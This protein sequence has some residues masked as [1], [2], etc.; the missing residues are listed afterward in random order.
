MKHLLLVVL[1]GCI[2]ANNIL[3]YDECE[4]SDLGNIETTN[5]NNQ[6]NIYYGVW[7]CISSTEIY[8]GKTYTGLQVGETLTI[9][10][11]GTYKSTSSDMGKSGIF[12]VEGNSFIATTNDGRGISATISLPDGLLTMEGLSDE[13]V[14][15]TYVFKKI[16][17]SIPIEYCGVWDCISSTETYK[18][19]TYTGLQ[20]GEAI[21]IDAD[22]TYESTSSDIGKAGTFVLE[23]NIFKATTNDGRGISATISLSDDLLTMEGF[24]EEGVQFSYVFKVT[25]D[26]V[27]FKK[28]SPMKITNY[29]GILVIEGVKNGK[30]VTIYSLSGVKIGAAI[31]T[32]H[33]AVINTALQSGNIVLIKADGK[34]LKYKCR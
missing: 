30:L 7:E 26:K 11:N 25:I 31:A 18:G 13:G 16:G 28:T 19:K 5:F 1:L 23:G 29:S 20:V 6:Q 24:S 22:G 3:A 4:Q 12:A 17:D 14:Q 15:F 10:P 34:S 2:Y 8:R 21:T 27:S 33:F 9:F 32:N